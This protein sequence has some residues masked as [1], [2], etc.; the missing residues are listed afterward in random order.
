MARC[1]RGVWTCVAAGVVGAMSSSSQAQRIDWT[2]AEPTYRG[3][4]AA[5]F[6]DARGVLVMVGGSPVGTDDST[7]EWNGSHWLAREA[8]SSPSVAGHQM[9]YDSVRR[10]TLLFGGF[11]SLGGYSNRTWEYDGTTWTERIGAAPS[12]RSVHA[13]SY[14]P[15]R[16]VCV[17]F[18]GYDSIGPVG[19]TWEWDGTL[20]TK[21]AD[22]GPSPRGSTAMA[23]DPIRRVTVLFGGGNYLGDTWEWDGT[24]WTQRAS[25]GPAPRFGHSLVFDP[26]EGGV[27]LVSGYGHI[28]DTS[29]LWVWDGRS[30]TTRPGTFAF[31]SS[32]DEAVYDSA[33][34]RIVCVNPFVQR[35]FDRVGNTWELRQES[36]PWW[37]TSGSFVHDSVR[38]RFILFGGYQG[39]N[40]RTPSDET[41]EYQFPRW[42]QRTLHPSP[43]ARGEALMVYDPVRRVTVLFGGRYRAGGSASA[44]YTYLSDTWEYDGSAWRQAATTGPDPE[45]KS[46]MLFDGTRNAVIILGGS[47][48]T[49]TWVWNG[50]VWAKSEIPCPPISASALACF[51]EN[52]GKVMLFSTRNWLWNGASWAPGSVDL[53]PGLQNNGRSFFNPMTRRVAIPGTSMSA[54][55]SVY[56]SL[57]EFDGDAWYKRPLVE[58]L[59]FRG[60][61]L[62]DRRTKSFIGINRDREHSLDVY[63]GTD[64]CVPPSVRSRSADLTTCSALPIELTVNATVT[65]PQTFQ[66]CKGEP[67]MPIGF[68]QASTFRLDSPTP[69]DSGVYRCLITNRCGMTYSEP[70]RVEVRCGADFDGSVGAPDTNDIDAFFK[71]W[72]AGQAIADVD[73][74]G[75]MPDSADLSAFFV[76]WLDGGC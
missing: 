53:F 73:C 27:A 34:K 75:G 46:I 65:L 4:A 40:T 5:A 41:W 59:W 24:T 3:G 20:W 72:S 19:D 17:L 52:L 44:P 25:G 33:R 49:E 18:G 10:K 48:S 8:P 12:A 39:G 14:D 26:A 28:A 54:T 38:E 62:P 68:A 69:A 45:K 35:S 70:I 67:P 23:Y 51:D 55:G 9:V 71:A 15:D 58:S 66:W 50:S 56:E 7:W 36:P 60:L 37:R 32:D 16:R 13:M 42:Q 30:W 47:A 63:L 76:A 74:S 21:K 29:T 57:F 64:P 61:I 43:P 31:P 22:T 1:G 2:P 11:S 6:D